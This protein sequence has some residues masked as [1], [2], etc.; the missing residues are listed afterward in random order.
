MKSNGDE[1]SLSVQNLA[2]TNEITI[3]Q[4]IGE[5]KRSGKDAI[6]VLVE[7]LKEEGSLCNIAA[8]VLGEFGEDASEAAEELS[9]LLTSHAE[10]TRMAAAISLMR[11]GKPSLP[12]V[13][14][15]AQESEGQSCF[16]ASWCIAWIDPA[17]IEPKMYECL[18]HEHEHPSG[19]V[20]PFAAEEA[21][22]KLIAFQLKDKE[23]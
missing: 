10:D 3:V 12:F 13:I 16:W 11:I 4:A 23:D 8:A 19:I 17:C 1:L 14:K 7:A 15:I 2:N 21:L 6:P 18:K 22:G 20:A 5:L 9:R